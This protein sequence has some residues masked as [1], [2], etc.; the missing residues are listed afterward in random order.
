MD[1]GHEEEKS[2]VESIWDLDDN[3]NIL[4]EFGYSLVYG[5]SRRLPP[6]HLLLDSAPNIGPLISCWEINKFENCWYKSVRSLEVL[7]LLFQ[8][9]LNLSS[10][11]RVMSGPIL[12]ALSRNRWSGGTSLNPCIPAGVRAGIPDVSW[13]HWGDIVD[14]R[15]EDRK[16][17]WRVKM[18]HW[19]HWI[20]LDSHFQ[21]PQTITPTKMTHSSRRCIWRN[22]F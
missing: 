17:Y 14:Y 20:G 6:D 18:W 10:S 4:T 3:E 21:K 7:K 16:I 9:F 13:V 22:R 1:Y 15:C 8:Q 19:C 2:L 5:W 12:G 11:Q